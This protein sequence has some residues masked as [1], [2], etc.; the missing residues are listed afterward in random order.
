VERV[1]YRTSPR[2][3]L[4][5]LGLGRPGG[6]ALALAGA[7]SVIVLGVFPLF[8]AVTGAD[9][10]LQSS[11]LWLL[12]GLF[13]FNGLAEE[14]VWRGFAFRRLREGRSYWTAVWWTMPLIAPT[15]I[16]IVVT[17]GPMI[18][19]GAMLVGA[20]TS[21]PLSYLYETGGSTIWAP[22]V[23]HSAIDSFKLFLIPASAVTTF[24]LLLIAVSLLVPLLCLA[25]PR[26]FLLPAVVRTA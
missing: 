25:V 24:S 11:W 17:L 2:A 23:V 9:V 4:H 15:H 22:A 20:V 12:V 18:G 1:L 6:R 16:P 8:A 10:Q 21:L 3:A 5:L 14:L 13:A 19:V 26:R 7:V